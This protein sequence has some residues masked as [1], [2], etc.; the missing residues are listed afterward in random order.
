MQFSWQY[1]RWEWEK[2]VLTIC[3]L[4]I[5]QYQC[6]SLWLGL[7][8]A[9]GER[10]INEKKIFAQCPSNQQKQQQQYQPCA[11]LEK[12]DQHLWYQGLVHIYSLY[13]FP[14]KLPLILIH[15]TILDTVEMLATNDVFVTLLRFLFFI[16]CSRCPALL[17]ALHCYLDAFCC[18]YFRLSQ[19][20]RP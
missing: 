18:I 20:H 16:H 17:T 6:R 12:Y 10:T 3:D 9:K 1:T 7:S 15:N 14:K 2:H 13:L 11:E 5:C 19:L 4:T 8:A